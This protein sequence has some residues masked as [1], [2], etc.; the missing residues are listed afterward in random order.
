ME[1]TPFTK[2][3]AEEIAEDF[4]DLVGTSLGSSPASPEIT[5]VLPAP[6]NRDMSDLFIKDVIAGTMQWEDPADEY[7]VMILGIE[8]GAPVLALYIRDYITANG[9]RYN[10]PQNN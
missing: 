4:E 7:D 1:I 3:Q 2:Q 10:F 9:I 6:F 5:H 8:N